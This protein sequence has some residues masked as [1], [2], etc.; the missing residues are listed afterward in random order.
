MTDEEYVAELN[1]KRRDRGYTMDL[2]CTT[3][4]EVKW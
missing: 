2:H 3:E 1:L 4:T